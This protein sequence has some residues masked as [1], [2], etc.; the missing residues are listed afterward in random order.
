MLNT[1]DQELSFVS[2]S[3]AFA[4]SSPLRERYA[5]RTGVLAFPFRHTPFDLPVNLSERR[6][7]LSLLFQGRKNVLPAGYLG[8]LSLFQG[9]QN[10]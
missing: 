7:R 1:R 8:G 5:R 9:R 3:G 10:P 2:D 4:L 6:D